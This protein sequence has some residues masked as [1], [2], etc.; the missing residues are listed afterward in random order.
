MLIFY[1]LAKAISEFKTRQKWRV[2]TF[3]AHDFFMIA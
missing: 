2:F 3:L 1:R